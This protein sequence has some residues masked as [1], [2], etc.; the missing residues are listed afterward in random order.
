LAHRPEGAG[1]DDLGH[2][3]LDLAIGKR[4]D[5]LVQIELTRLP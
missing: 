1:Q 4:I 2:I 3:G 5:R